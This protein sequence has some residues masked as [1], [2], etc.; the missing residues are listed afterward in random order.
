MKTQFS[1]LLA[2]SAVLTGAFVTLAAPTH[3][4]TLTCEASLSGLVSGTSACE[5]S[6][7]A[8]QDF[9]N[10]DPMTVNAEGFFGNT[11]WVFGGKIGSDTGYAGTKDGLSGTW[12]ISSV[13]QSIGND[14]MLVFKSGNGT[15]LTAYDVQDGVTSG[16]WD[17]P[18]L[19]SVFGFNG[20][21]VKDVSHISVYHRQETTPTPPRTRVPEPTSLLGLGLV[22]SGMVIARRRSVAG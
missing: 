22:A 16:T 21:D 19:K 15:F 11:D 8:S 4:A 17:S 12:D 7:S 9:L 14:I 18:F 13:S 20:G 10:T 6:N 1:A 2:S 3:A 5:R